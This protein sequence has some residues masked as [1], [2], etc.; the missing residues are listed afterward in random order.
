M[1]VV[2]SSTCGGVVMADRPSL[3]CGSV[4]PGLLGIL[5]LT[6]LIV[7]AL[8]QR[9]ALSQ[10]TELE[11]YP[12]LLG[13]SLEPHRIY[14]NYTGDFIMRFPNYDFLLFNPMRT[15]PSIS[16]QLARIESG[17]NA[18]SGLR[19][20]PHGPIVFRN[21]AGMKWDGSRLFLH[22]AYPYRMVERFRFSLN[23]IGEPLGT[24]WPDLE[25]EIKSTPPLRAPKVFDPPVGYRPLPPQTPVGVMPQDELP[26]FSPSGTALKPTD[27]VPQYRHPIPVGPIPTQPVS[28][29][30]VRPWPTTAVDPPWHDSLGTVAPHPSTIKR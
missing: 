18:A 4:R 12:D 28:T 14:R 9:T 7:G 19:V 5:I 27:L 6:V 20:I 1:E 10:R 17:P 29:V 8:P 13:A 30:R 23:A 26:K 3:S 22:P 25:P 2:F 24:Q 15:S 21:D 11:P 16:G